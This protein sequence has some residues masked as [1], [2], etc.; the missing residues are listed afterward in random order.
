MV[1]KQFGH[2]MFQLNPKKKKT[3]NFKY[4]NSL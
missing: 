3:K 4:E 2:I 1:N